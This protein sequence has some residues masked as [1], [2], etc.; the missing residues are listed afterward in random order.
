MKT[1][2]IPILLGALLMC[3]VPF[4]AGSGALLA[5]GAAA[6]L[7]FAGGGPRIALLTSSITIS[8]LNTAFGSVYADGSKGLRDLVGQVFEAAEFDTL[9]TIERTNLTE[10]RKATSTSTAVLQ[11]FQLDFTPSSSITFQPIRI[12]LQMVKLDMTLNSYE[13]YNSFIGFMH[14][15]GTAPTAQ[16]YVQYILNNHI[17]GQVQEDYELN[18][19][20]AGVYSAPTPGTPGAVGTSMNGFK[21]LIN[22]H[23]TASEITPIATGVAPTDAVDFCTWVENFFEQ[24]NNKDIDRPMTIAMNKTLAARFKRGNRA[25]Y[26]SSYMATTD[27]AQLHY[28]PNARVQGFAAMGSSAK[29]FCTEKTNIIKGVNMGPGSMFNFEGNDR[30]VKVW[31]DWMIG[32]GILRK[33]RFYTND[34]D[35]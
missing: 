24:V 15:Q 2:S 30:S 5:V 20:Y 4:L 6:L 10:I 31:G 35:T 12:P 34:Q 22:D 23:I 3:T 13:V 8:A 19:A 17:I 21:K 7:A 25:K 18:L 11:P 29:I 1:P 28:R 26:S 32:F 33:D 14:S 27:L 9:F 16:A